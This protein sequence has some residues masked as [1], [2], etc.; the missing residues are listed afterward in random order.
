MASK[1]GRMSSPKITKLIAGYIMWLWQ[2]TRLNQAQI[3]S[4]LGSLNQGRVSEVING[5]RFPGVE[6]MPWQGEIPY[7]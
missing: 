7:A 1:N 5:K 2:N 6:P 3:A 4:L